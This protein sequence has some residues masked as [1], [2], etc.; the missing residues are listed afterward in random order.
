MSGVTV[1]QVA[2][3]IRALELGEKPVC[4]H[5]S[6]RSFGRLEAGA[7]TVVHGILE[8]GCTVLVPTF[9]HQFAVAPPDDDQPRQ[10]AFDYSQ[11]RSSPGLGRAFHPDAEVEPW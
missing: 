5:V 11:P 6:M 8:A 3:G 4:I 10:N 9:S 2:D 7:A 1:T